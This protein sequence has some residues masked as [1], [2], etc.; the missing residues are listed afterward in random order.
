M[1]VALSMDPSNISL[2]LLIGG[3][4]LRVSRPQIVR[5]GPF[6]VRALPAHSPFL[7]GGPTSTPVISTAPA[8]VASNLFQTADGRIFAFSNGNQQ[9]GKLSTPLQNYN[10]T[11][12]WTLLN[13]S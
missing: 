4:V 2:F 9:I 5:S 7:V 13:K 11:I 10:N 1:L 3:S 12:F 8:G 6:A